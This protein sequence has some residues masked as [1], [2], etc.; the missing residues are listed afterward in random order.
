M[1]KEREKERGGKTVREEAGKREQGRNYARRLT[2][3]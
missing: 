1:K 2:L 3:F